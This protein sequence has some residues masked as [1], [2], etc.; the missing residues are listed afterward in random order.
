MQWNSLPMLLYG[1]FQLGK[2]G[3]LSRVSR[4][5]K[6]GQTHS[7]SNIEYGEA[8]FGISDVRFAVV[9][10]ETRGSDISAGVLGVINHL[11]V[12]SH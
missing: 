12:H 1:S 9:S 4:R 8:A 10:I 7:S 11:S 3:H 5:C 2:S 6:C